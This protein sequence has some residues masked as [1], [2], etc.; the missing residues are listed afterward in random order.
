MSGQLDLE[1]HGSSV[2]QPDVGDSGKGGHQ[3][4]ICLIWQ[5][6]SGRATISSKVEG[7]RNSV[8]D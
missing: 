7:T 5:I 1:E 8:A 3:D 6:L 4:C 2:A